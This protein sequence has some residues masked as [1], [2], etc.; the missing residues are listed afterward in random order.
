MATRGQNASKE[1]RQLSQ[2]R[3]RRDLTY[4]ALADA[5][6][7]GHATLHGLLKWSNVPPTASERTLYKIREYLKRTA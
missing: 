4:E 5:I 1:V 2:L 6:G 3:L 7:I